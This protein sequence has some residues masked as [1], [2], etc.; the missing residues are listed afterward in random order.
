VFA[1]DFITGR[2][3]RFKPAADAN[4]MFTARKINK[5]PIRTY[6]RLRRGN[7]GQMTFEYRSWWLFGERQTLTLPEGNYVVGRG[8]FYPDLML[9]ESEKMRTILTMPPRYRTHE[10]EIA[11]IYSIRDVQDVGLLKGF[12]AT[13]NWLRSLFGVGSTRE[14]A[15]A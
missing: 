7:A 5:V 4:W 11:A 3:R 13:W 10:D 1:W 2:R 8:L 14:P 9:P 12:K 15:A 6:G